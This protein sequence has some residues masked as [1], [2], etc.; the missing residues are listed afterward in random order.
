MKLFSI[1]IGILFTATI[2]AQTSMKEVSDPEAIAILDAIKSEYDKSQAHKLNFD[3]IIEIPGQ[4]EEIQSGSL[5]QSG[6]RFVL[7]MPEQ[8]IITDGTTAWVHLKELNEVQ[9]NNAD[10]DND[11]DFISPSNLMQMHKSDKFIFMVFN[12]FA[13]NG[14]QVTQIEAKPTDMDAEYS[15][16]RITLD[17]K[18]KEMVRVKIFSRDGSRYTMKISEHQKDFPIDN[19][20]FA[21]DPEDYDDVIIEDLRL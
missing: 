17:E 15:K 7:D 10:F 13:E 21:F 16:L 8:K 19:D 9:I 20:T 5:I 14:R 11:E 6:D 1:I 18:K 2:F 3:L 4:G 12:K